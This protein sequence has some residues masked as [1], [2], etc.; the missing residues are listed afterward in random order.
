MAGFKVHLSKNAEAPQYFLS[1]C[2]LLEGSALEGRQRDT[3]TKVHALE[4]PC[5]VAQLPYFDDRGVAPAQFPICTAYLCSLLPFARPVM[6]HLQSWKMC[7]DHL[8]M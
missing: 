3:V 1:E 4:Q 5:T 7:I 2:A 6:A 8:L